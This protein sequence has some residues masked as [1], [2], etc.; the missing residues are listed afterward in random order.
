MLILKD[1]LDGQLA[2]G[3]DLQEVFYQCTFCANCALNCPA[4]VNVAEVLQEA[5]KEMVR[6][7]DGHPVFQGLQQVLDRK[8]NIYGED[9]RDHFGREKNKQAEIVFFIGCVGSFREIESTRQTLNLLDRLEVDYTLID[10]ACCSGIL[11]EVGYPISEDRV[12]ENCQRH[13]KDRGQN[14][15]YRLS[16]L[17]SDL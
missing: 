2:F 3:Q 6:L 16:L 11:E 10:E 7:G 12:R 5:R 8:A 17:L 9:G 13:F 1:V 15:H 14:R 4:G